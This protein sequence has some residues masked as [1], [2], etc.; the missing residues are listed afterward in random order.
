MTSWN[1]KYIIGIDLGTTNSVVS[2]V[3]AD[4]PIHDQPDIQIFNVPQVTAPG[5]V[6]NRAMLPSALL[7]PGPDDVPED[8]MRL[9]WHRGASRKWVVGEFALTRGAELA[10]R[11]ITSA[12]SWLCN[13]MVD[14]NGAILPWEGPGDADKLS[15]V[16]ATA[17]ILRHIRDAWNHLMADA[18][19]G[20]RFEDQD[21]LITV[22]ASF[23]PV[24]RELT[25]KAAESAGIDHL[26][27]IEEP[28]AAFYALIEHHHTRWREMVQPGDVVL[29][30]DVGG[31]TS[32]F[33]LIQVDE[34][35]GN[36]TLDRIAVGDHLLVGGDNMDLAL[37]HTVAQK[38]ASKG[39]TLDAWQ[40]RSLW[41]TCRQ[42]KE[43]LLGDVDM[44]SYPVAILGRGSRL[45]GGTIK[46]EL[47]AE[48]IETVMLNGFFPF[49]EAD[50][51][52]VTPK[53]SGIREIGL[54]Y[55]ADPAVTRHLSAFLNRQASIAGHA[56]FPTA[57]LFNGGVMKAERLRHHVLKI[58]NTWHRG[59]GGETVREIEASNFD[60]AVARGAAY[61]G[62][63]RRGEGIR[64]R[65][66]LGR[67][68][69][70]GVAASMP[71]VPG[72]AAPT[73][74][75]CIA[76]FGM[77]EGQTAAVTDRA[78]ALVVGEPVKFEFLSS[79]TRTDD[80]PGAMVEDWHGA[81]TPVTTLETTLEGDTG[82]T[83]P[84]TLEIEVTETGTLKIWCV[85]RDGADRWK[86]E[87]NVRK[88]K[89]GESVQP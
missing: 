17:R 50:A 65:A 89:G 47:T 1:P 41:H 83:I 84:V 57:V 78:F 4:I 75:L 28:T 7:I 42:A 60:L 40:M 76:G 6:E 45:I 44:N 54:S 66:G 24:A 49:C 36:L 53:A 72:I 68:Y 20:H 52:P 34:K 70:I 58:F 79:A 13:T 10:H 81:I 82:Q 55:E 12:K 56:L 5:V 33:S 25:G 39:T 51:R 38:L 46:T 77:E 64:I 16:E 11:L 43:H 29:V 85:A 14:R 80:L 86:L 30:C 21:I 27:L 69:Y 73:K 37:A 63:A 2:Y 23:D 48:D 8:A 74:A 88:Q 19:D 67:S 87:F 62:M 35:E 15:P 3:R 18:D 32:D 26:T 71:A 59:E 31:G 22:P 61:Y 9:P